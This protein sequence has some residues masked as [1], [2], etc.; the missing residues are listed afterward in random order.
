MKQTV[1]S[2]NPCEKEA[3]WYYITE[4]GVKFHLCLT[5]GDAFLLGQG[6]HA[7]KLHLVGE[8]E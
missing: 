7:T 2:N 8:R 6:N 1:C 3:K 4:N 5:C